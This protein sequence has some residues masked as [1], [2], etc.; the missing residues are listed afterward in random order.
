V[1]GQRSNRYY[2]IPRCD[3]F[4][5]NSRQS[6]PGPPSLPRRHVVGCFI[7]WTATPSGEKP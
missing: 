5:R 4:S 1:T 2:R 6:S 3:R 7:G